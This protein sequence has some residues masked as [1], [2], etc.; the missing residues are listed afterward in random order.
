MADKKVMITVFSILTGAIVYHVVSFD[1][2][3]VISNMALPEPS[4]AVVDCQDCLEVTGEVCE[5]ENDS[6][7][8]FASCENWLQCTED[9]VTLGQNQECFDDCDVAHS[10]THSQ[11]NAM[12]SCMCDVCIGQCVD[13]CRADG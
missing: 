10:D 2:A 11:C 12:K 5:M 13:M 9:C 4:V 7:S 6:C 8:E 1:R 3:P